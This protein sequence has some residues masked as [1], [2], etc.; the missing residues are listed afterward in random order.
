MELFGNGIKKP[1][2]GPV[3]SQAG[4]ERLARVQADLAAEEQA[5]LAAQ[6]TEQPVPRTIYVAFREAL[7]RPVAESTLVDLG[8]AAVS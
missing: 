3:S 8:S 1:K 7:P 4:A 6:V 5:M 2:E